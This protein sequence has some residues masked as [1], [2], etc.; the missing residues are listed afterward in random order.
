M[1]SDYPVTP[2]MITDNNGFPPSGDC[3]IV[4]PSMGVRALPSLRAKLFKQAVQDMRALELLKR[5]IGKDEV[6]SLMEDNNEPIEFDRYPTSGNYILALR[7][8]V[9]A[10]IGEHIE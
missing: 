10:L 3:F 4:Y 2:Y 5:F 7:Q 8:R 6:I 1:L 9:K